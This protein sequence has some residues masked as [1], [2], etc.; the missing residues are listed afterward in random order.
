[1]H[2]GIRALILFLLIS[3]SAFAQH[4]NLKKYTT[5]NGL[6]NSVVQKI[7][8]D[9]KGYYWFA[10]TNGLSRFDG[11]VFKNFQITDGLPSSEITSILEDSKNNLWIGTSKGLA[12]YDGVKINQFNIPGI[13]PI[14]LFYLSRPSRNCLVC[15]IWK[16][17]F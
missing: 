2:V 8:Q 17:S 4:F 6:A 15:N 9:E 12:R 5:K 16:W 7:I 1:M 11:K 10:T 14:N 3:S 13:T